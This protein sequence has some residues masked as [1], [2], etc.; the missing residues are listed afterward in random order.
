MFGLEDA[1]IVR[2]HPPDRGM[3]GDAHAMAV[4]Q[5]DRAKEPA[6]VADP[7]AAGHLAVAVQREIAGQ[8]RAWGSV[9]A[10]R[11]DRRDPGAN[12]RPG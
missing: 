11:Q 10:T 5:A 12:L 2:D 1:G 9:K 3:V 4:G 8:N 6:R 7:V